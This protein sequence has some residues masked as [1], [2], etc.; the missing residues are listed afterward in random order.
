M[1][2]PQSLRRLIAN[3]ANARLS[4]GPR[5]AAG[6]ARARLNARRHGLAGDLTG[7]PDIEQLMGI[8]GRNV[9]DLEQRAQ[10]L[11]IA[12]SQCAL[13]RART[14]RRQALQPSSI[15]PAQEDSTPQH[16]NL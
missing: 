8:L 14:A 13:N 2:K 11:E 5:T 6:K 7:D 9:A 12:E 15:G 3:R 4:T 10:V 1:D 16:W